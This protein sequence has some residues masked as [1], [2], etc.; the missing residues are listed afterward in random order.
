[1]VVGSRR[2][3]RGGEEG[4]RKGRR[5]VCRGRYVVVRYDGEKEKW[6]YGWV[7]IVGVKGIL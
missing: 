1:M 5:E 4:E 6:V 3:G 2:G 7:R